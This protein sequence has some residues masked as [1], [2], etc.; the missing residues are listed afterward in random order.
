MPSP[1]MWGIIAVGGYFAFSF[2]KKLKAKKDEDGGV[3]YV[4]AF[5][6][7]LKGSAT[8]IERNPDISETGMGFSNGQPLFYNEIDHSK[9][10]FLGWIRN[11]MDQ[12]DDRKILH[13]FYRAKIAKDV[14]Y[15]WF[16]PGHKIETTPCV[17][18]PGIDAIQKQPGEE[19]GVPPEGMLIFKRSMDGKRVS[20]DNDARWRSML[21][22]Q[23]HLNTV[24][25]DM[26]L[27][28]RDKERLQGSSEIAD[29]V[30]SAIENKLKR[31]KRAHDAASGRSSSGDMSP[32]GGSPYG[33]EMYSPDA[34][35]EGGGGSDSM[36][37]FEG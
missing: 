20:Q 25:Q 4:D 28:L 3:G 7:I 29:E 36:W 35:L 1:V 10:R 14:K 22:D 5:K 32:L 2:Y 9:G 30:I 11:D 16:F 13:N 19:P 34:G 24:M 23:K 31:S 26:I 37:N 21:H 18:R 33:R 6:E 8:P 15:F 17:F 27:N 12:A